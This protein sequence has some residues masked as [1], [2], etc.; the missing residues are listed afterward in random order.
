MALV[1]LVSR[2]KGVLASRARGGGYGS[3]EPK[4]DDGG[5]LIMKAERKAL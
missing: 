4:Q 5:V 2:S 3:R 1:A